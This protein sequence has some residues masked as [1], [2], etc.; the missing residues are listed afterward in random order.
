V[1]NRHREESKYECVFFLMRGGLQLEGTLPQTTVSVEEILCTEELEHRPPRPSDYAK[2][3]RALVKLVSALTDS[4]GTVLQTLV[5]TILDITQAHSAGLS[6]LSGDGKTPDA[7]GDR[8][9][10]PAIAGVWKPHI[11]GCTPRDFGPEG[12]ALDRNCSLLFRHL[13]RRYTYLPTPVN[14]CLLVPF[15]V[16]GKAAG[17]IWALAL[18]EQRKFD[19]EDDRVMASLGKFASSACQALK[20]IEDLKSQGAE[21]EKA[22]AE[23]RELAYSEEKYRLVVQTASDAIVSM[24]HQGLILSANSAIATI[25]GYEP[26]E[27]TGKPMTVLMPQYL[28]ELH[29]NGFRRYLATGQRH[30]NW[31]GVELTAL[32]KNGEE[33]PV[34]VSFGE[35]TRDGHKVFTGFLR[36]ISKRKQAEHA[37]RHSE[38]FLAQGQRLSR[39]G[40]YFWRV[41]TD[42]IAGTDELSR[43]YELDPPL[44]PAG[45]RIRV[46]PEDLTLYQQMVE[47]ARNGG[48]DFETQYRL[49]MP[50]HSIKYLHAVVH[51]TRDKDGELEYIAAVQD[52]TARRLSEEALDKIRSELARVSR[53]TTMGEL[54]A[55]IAHE[56][57]QPLTGVT[58]N[59]NACMRLLAKRNLEPE[60]LQQALEGIVADAT[61]A[62]AVIARI[63]AFIKN[64]PVARCELDI[65]DVI[66]EVL[67]IAGHEL[68]KKK[69]AV[70]RQ[71]TNTPVVRADR[72]QLQQVLLNL[73]MN[74][75]EAMT[76]VTYRPRVLWM[77]SQVD[78]SGDVQVSVRD[79][80]PGFGSE[81]DRLFTPFFTTKAS[82]MG[83]G[84]PISLSLIESHGG[85][86]WA[87]PNS[88][89]GAAFFFTVPAAGASTS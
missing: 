77:Q 36:D 53:L 30:L 34:E 16:D 44:T 50:D 4:P 29:D 31:H 39:V 80:G 48:N 60:I 3:N 32:R 55:S 81:P 9:F 79:S 26:A 67:A 73:I 17:T 10:W 23:V 18:D 51:A 24:D 57:N 22:E 28:R 8:F 84:L 65:N 19:A 62:S 72:V 5:E 85:R 15:H 88:P 78:E 6:L 58:N 14:E 35:L 25:F 66:Q 11:G 47:Q 63:R 2:E 71:L 87:A 82:G 68:Q 41:A 74:G 69:V 76:S 89:H 64:S 46:H 13:E 70:E 59:A 61:R 7:W 37:L 83:M 42:E 54:A 56:V 38:A 21:R 49:L 33:F 40:T 45:F 86:L 20:H 27:L 12:D 52:V 43:I 1:E 75:I